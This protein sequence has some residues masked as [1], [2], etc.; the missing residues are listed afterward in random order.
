MLTFEKYI[1]LGSPVAEMVITF[2]DKTEKLF[3][4]VPEPIPLEK[5]DVDPTRILAD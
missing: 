4:M 2:P 3:E 1:E 5:R